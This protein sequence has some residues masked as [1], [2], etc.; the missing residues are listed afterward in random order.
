MAGDGRSKKRSQVEEFYFQSLIPG[1]SL[2][3]ESVKLD[4]EAHI[5]GL[6][7]TSTPSWNADYD[8]GRADPV[9]FYGSF[10][11]SVTVSFMVVAVNKEEH[12]LNYE[13]LRKLG[14]FTYPIHQGGSGYNAPHVMYKIGDLLHGIGVIT[15][16]DYTWNTE[17]PWIADDK[18]KRRPLITEVGMGIQVLTDG[19]GKRPDYNKAGYNYFGTR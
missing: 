19:Y 4:F 18:D 13:S 2:G 17:I 7:D 9:V 11:R 6:T 12:R 8:M 5:V 16:L 14:T 1:K 3:A 15:S 10:S